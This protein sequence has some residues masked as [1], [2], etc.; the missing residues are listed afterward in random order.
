[1]TQ[2][3]AFVHNWSK[4][5]RGHEQRYPALP[6]A[7]A[8]RLP[9]INPINPITR[10]D[11]PRFVEGGPAGEPDNRVVPTRWAGTDDGS[12]LIEWVTRL[13]SAQTERRLLW[14]TA[15]TPR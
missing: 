3:E 4:V 1:M 9:L 12:V 6:G 14:D 11:L 2:A 7:A 5:W 10:E 8:R 13:T 15:I